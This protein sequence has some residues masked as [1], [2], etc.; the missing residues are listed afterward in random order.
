MLGGGIPLGFSAV[1]TGPSGCGKTVLATSFLK[2][3]AERGEHGILAS[4]ENGFFQASNS[5]L[6]DIERALS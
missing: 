2:A 1:I 4:Y 6:Q 5:P 3:G